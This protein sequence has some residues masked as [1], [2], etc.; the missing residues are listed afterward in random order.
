MSNNFDETYNPSRDFRSGE[1]EEK[2]LS[3]IRS[4]I[5]EIAENN[6][7]RPE[8]KRKFPLKKWLISILVLI[9]LVIGT[10]YYF[11]TKNKPAHEIVMAY[12][13][14]YPN[15]Q[16]FQIRGNKNINVLRDA[17]KAYDKPNY[18]QAIEL[19]DENFTNLSAEDKFYYAVALQGDGQWAAS[20]VPLK[21]ILTTVNTDYK[22]AAIW[23]LALARLMSN[24][25]D[26]AIELLNELKNMPSSF[27]SKAVNLL[28]ELN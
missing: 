15:Y 16:Q 4:R 21:K 9:L 26:G 12:F 20:I 14:P 24:N 23:H 6:T 19:F 3:S 25:N 22:P 18:I 2:S 7:N 5:D 11:T 13:E 10:N 8:A 27:Q 17:Y 1:N 28:N